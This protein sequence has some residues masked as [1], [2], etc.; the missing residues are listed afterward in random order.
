MDAPRKPSSSPRT[1]KIENT[2]ENRRFL[3]KLVEFSYISSFSVKNKWLI[4]NHF[5]KNKKNQ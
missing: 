1:A 4:V 2:I 3:E 5:R